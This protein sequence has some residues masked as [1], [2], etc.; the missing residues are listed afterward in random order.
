M[1]L[2]S[3]PDLI[4]FDE[5]TTALDVTI[6]AQ[7]L[8]MMK[9]LKNKLQTSVIMI[10]HDL[11]VVANF[12]E[13]VAVIY[14]GDVLEYG[15]VRHIFKETAH[16]YTKGLF[17]SLPKLDS[18]EPRLKPIKGLMPDPTNL[19]DGCKFCDRCPDATD[20]CFKEAPESVEV[21]EGHLCKCF[22][23]EVK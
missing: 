8:D 19:P 18:T 7:V 21:S 2:C 13:S 5:P 10:T 4:V 1:A 6:Q 17:N 16:P 11:G 9:D 20:K 14:A 22:Y 12:C 23:A 3:E 15:T